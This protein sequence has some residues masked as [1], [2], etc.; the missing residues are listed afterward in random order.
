MAAPPP[1]TPSLPLTGV[2]VLVVDDERLVLSVI[3]RMLTRAGAE[4][5]MAN[6]ADEAERAFHGATRPFDVVLTDILMPGRDG[7]SLARA[8]R[9][10][11][12]DVRTVFMT[13]WSENVAS[14]PLPGPLLMKPFTWDTLLETITQAVTVRDVRTV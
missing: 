13:A 12:P 11:R 3:A 4:A 6:D 14:E 8:L 7:L 9:E 2:R 1:N 10:R 5:V